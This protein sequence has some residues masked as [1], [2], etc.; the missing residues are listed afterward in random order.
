MNAMLDALYTVAG[1]V[2][3][4]AGSGQIYQLI[5]VGRSSEMSLPTWSLWFM[6]QLITFAYSIALKAFLLAFFNLLWLILYATVFIL[7]VYYRK[8]PRMIE[9]DTLTAAMPE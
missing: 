2:A 5:K 3:I 6:T 4:V 7:I 1:T 9:A 8:H